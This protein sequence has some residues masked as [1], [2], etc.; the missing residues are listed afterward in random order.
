[1]RRWLFL[2]VLL[3]PN[4]GWAAPGLDTVSFSPYWG[5][6]FI[7]VL[8]SLALFP[9]LL[10]G[11]WHKH[12][13]KVAAFWAMCF[14]MPY[15]L[16]FGGSQTLTMVSHTLLLEYFPFITLLFALFTITGGIRITGRWEGSPGS[17]TVI[18]G[19]GTVLASIIGTTGASMLL[20]HPLIRAIRWRKQR[21]H[22][23]IFFIFLVSNIGGALTPLG[24][25]PLFLGFL[26]GVPFFWPAVH[27]FIPFVL[28]SVPLLLIFYFV[29]R[30]LYPK[31]NPEKHPKTAGKFQIKG[32]LNIVWLMGVMGFV[33]LSGAWHSEG[34]IEIFSTQITY[35]SLVR[36]IGLITLAILSLIFSKSE[37]RQANEFHWEPIVEILKIFLAIFITVVP[38][39]TMLNAGING[40]FADLI[41]QT[42]SGGV[43]HNPTYFWSTGLLS[44]F[45]DNAPTYLVFYFMA[46]GNALVLST[47]LSDTLMSI[48]M[49]AVFM[50]ALTYIG[51]A[52][53]FMVRSIAAH[54]GIKMPSFFGYMVW[55]CGILLPL[56]ILLTLVYIR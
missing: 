40:P 55:S 17:N 5:I 29:D 45:L 23:I 42:T 20:I 33:L 34:G 10:E 7:G 9:I 25:P 51:N 27:L 30:W 41:A 48:S 47:T 13:G 37:D 36:E 46:G 16:Q 24:D 3:Y 11:F 39:I 1:M 15:F 14:L 32:K 50:G 22:I 26:Q 31:E 28:V 12:Y 6:P 52:P 4:M 2:V 49:G 53:N 54:K 44:S 56:F 43:P 38:V 35:P 18:L 8:L 21:K 19:I